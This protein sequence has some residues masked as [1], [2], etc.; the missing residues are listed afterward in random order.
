MSPT[1]ADGLLNTWTT[2]EVPGYISKAK[3]RQLLRDWVWRIRERVQIGSEV[4]A[5]AAESM[6]SPFHSD[7]KGNTKRRH[8]REGDSKTT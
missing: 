7:G 5:S 3:F 2:R 8:L 1:L 6:E 4:W